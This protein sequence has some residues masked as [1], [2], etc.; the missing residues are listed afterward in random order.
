M[1]KKM[2]LIFMAV[3]LLLTFSA[4]GGAP[5]AQTPPAQTP[6]GEPEAEDLQT[7]LDN[8]QAIELKMPITLADNHVLTEGIQHWADKVEEATQGKV[9]VTIYPSGTLMKSGTIYPGVRDGVAEVAEEDIAYNPAEFPLFSGIFMGGIQF[10]D[11]VNASLAAN[12]WIHQDFAEYNDVKMLWAYSMP[13]SVLMGNKRIEKLEDMTGTQVRVTGFCVSTVQLLGSTP[14]GLTMPETYDAL[15]K[16]TVDVNM[17]NP[18]T[19]GKP[20]NLAEVS[21]YVTLIPGISYIPHPI[22][23]NKRTWE[24]LPPAVQAEIERVSLEAVV[25]TGQLADDYYNSGLEFADSLGVEIIELSDAELAR[26]YEAI[27]PQHQAWIDEKN[28]AGLDG[29]GAFDILMELSDKY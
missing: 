8:M 17:A 10:D 19:L 20:N 14:V 22:F 6:G 11:C 3:C 15:L 12:E 25:E 24:S 16:G 7:A 27:T 21:K 13:P 1:L 28:A 4:C 2:S 5:A 23:M 26:W 29:Q 18:G 9:T